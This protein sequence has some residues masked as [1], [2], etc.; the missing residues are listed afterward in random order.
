VAIAKDHVHLVRCS[1]HQLVQLHDTET[2]AV[3]E[4][5]WTASTHHIKDTLAEP[6]MRNK[7]EY[8]AL[9]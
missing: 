8:A 6:V 9:R 3:Q 5:A 2:V 1:V 4:A 7:S